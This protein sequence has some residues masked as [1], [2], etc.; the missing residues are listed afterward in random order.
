MDVPVTIAE[1]AGAEMPW[2]DGE[3]FAGSLIGGEG[4]LTGGEDGREQMLEV[5]DGIWNGVRTDELHYVRWDDGET[6]LYAYRDDPWEME[7]LSEA[8]PE[9][10]AELDARLDELLEA[11]RA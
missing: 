2:A 4:S 11:S 5:M 6:E 9:V 3:S 10:V 7:D 1:L 8:R